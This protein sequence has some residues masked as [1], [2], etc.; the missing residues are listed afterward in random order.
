MVGHVGFVLLQNT[1]IPAN[2]LMLGGN[3]DIL[4]EGAKVII[5]D[6]DFKICAKS[7]N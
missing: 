3:Q 1:C 5:S 6:Q 2:I 4:V 7:L